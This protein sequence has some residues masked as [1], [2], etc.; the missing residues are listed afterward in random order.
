MTDKERYI[1]LIKSFGIGYTEEIEQRN[2]SDKPVKCIAIRHEEGHHAKV[3][4]YV[5]FCAEYL[6]SIDDG[7][8]L[9]LDI[10]E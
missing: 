8:F 5:G 9:Q 2:I 1:E 3:G 10:W 4:G 6:F 7:K